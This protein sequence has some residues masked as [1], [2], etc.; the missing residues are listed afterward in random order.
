M[1]SI[2]IATGDRVF[3]R[4]DTLIDAVQA[5]LTEVLGVPDWNRD[6]VVDAYDVRHRAVPTGHSERFTRVEIT[7]N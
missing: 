2:R 7:P 4:E 5:A 1:P 3:G 6:V